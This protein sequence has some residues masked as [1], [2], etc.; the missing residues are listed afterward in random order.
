MTD[1]E[2]RDVVE[3]YGYYSS[4]SLLMKYVYFIECLRRSG[5][6]EKVRRNL[7]VM[8]C[9]ASLRDH[10]AEGSLTLPPSIY[11]ANIGEVICNGHSCI[12]YD[13]DAFRVEQANGAPEVA[14]CRTLDS[15]AV[16]DASFYIYS[17]DRHDEVVVDVEPMAVHEVFFR[18]DGTRIN[19]AH[20]V[21]ERG[22]I[23]AC[24]GEV[25]FV[26]AEAK[27]NFAIINNRSGHF[28]PTKKHLGYAAEV[29]AKAL[30]IP[31]DHVF[32]LCVSR[33]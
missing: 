28:A 17:I 12:Q 32:P 7:D 5:L 6:C 1:L 30:E 2:F 26:R 14:R 9:Y 18:K 20:L 8:R 29:F 15:R 11:R 25:V 4:A 10:Y 27:V 16:V 13:A 23:S 33:G 24:A 21:A 19:H 31:M 3:R 22:L